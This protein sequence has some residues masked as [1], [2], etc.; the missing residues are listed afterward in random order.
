MV[1][2][3]EESD[4]GAE[5]VDAILVIERKILRSWITIYTNPEESH[6]S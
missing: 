2:P 6:E 5:V 1:R 3:K 4:A